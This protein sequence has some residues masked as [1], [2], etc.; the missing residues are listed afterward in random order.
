M[1][2]ETLAEML[3]SPLPCE[4]AREREFGRQ[5]MYTGIPTRS[6]PVT[7]ARRV[8]PRDGRKGLIR[9]QV[10]SGETVLCVPS[11]CVFTDSDFR[12]ESRFSTI[13]RKAARAPPLRPKDARPR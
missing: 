13:F 10:V 7:F 3:L 9:A 12:S 6:N 5:L 1:R 11:K 8:I 2:A 4:T